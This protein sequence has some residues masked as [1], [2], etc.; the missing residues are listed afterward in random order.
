MNEMNISWISDE[1]DRH[2]YQ[3]LLPP[4]IE[5]EE[6][7]LDKHNLLLRFIMAYRHGYGG[8]YYSYDGCVQELQRNINDMFGGIDIVRVLAHRRDNNSK[9][10]VCLYPFHIYRSYHYSYVDPHNGHKYIDLTFYSE[11]KMM[12]REKMLT[13]IREM[14]K[15]IFS[16]FHYC[17]F[18]LPTSCLNHFHDIYLL[19]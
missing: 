7:V 17:F 2:A 12:H 18:T 10:A 4:P 9:K 3:S 19:I 16:L 8:I 5:E 6:W 13:E 14:K 1:F 15:K 11:K